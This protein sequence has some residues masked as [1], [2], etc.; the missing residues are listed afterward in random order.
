MTT[1]EHEKPPV[2]ARDTRIHEAAYA[3]ILSGH[4]PTAEALLRVVGGSK[5]TVLAGLRTFWT[6]G[7]RARIFESQ[8]D[9][10]P[11]E[12]IK[13]ANELW[14]TAATHANER[15]ATS[16]AG[17]LD[18]LEED[19]RKLDEERRAMIS[20]EAALRGRI[21]QLLEQTQKTALDLQAARHEAQA[22]RERTREANE[23]ADA[24]RREAADIRTLVEQLEATIAAG[25]RQIE[26]AAQRA[27]EIEAVAANERVAAAQARAESAAIAERLND[28]LARA[29]EAERQLAEQRASQASVAQQVAETLRQFRAIQAHHSSELLR[30]S[31]EN[32]ERRK[33]LNAAHDAYVGN[34]LREIDQ[35]RTELRKSR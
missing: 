31:K 28:A 20:S 29:A 1:P 7:L 23:K 2:S 15:A 5:Q 22:E 9:S 25:R 19:R 26:D 18:N 13:V 35:L 10:A 21:E 30:I 11:P 8:D 17:M 27:A 33:E 4:Q 34:L 24:A 14:A 6:D 12:V 16:Y 32:D 3:M